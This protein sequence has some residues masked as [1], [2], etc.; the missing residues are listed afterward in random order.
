M[1]AFVG[2]ELPQPVRDELVQ[3]QAELRRAGADVNWVAAQNLHATVRF[4][5]DVTEEQRHA[6][7]QLLTGLASRTDTAELSLTHVGAFPSGAAPRVIWVGI[8]LGQG[9]LA[10]LVAELE[11]GLV[12]LGLP[13]EDRRFSAHVTLGRVRSPQNRRQLVRQLDGLHWT[14]PKPFRMIHV[15]LFQST[16]TPS[17]PIYTVLARLSLRTPVEV[18]PA[19]RRDGTQHPPA[20]R[21]SGSSTSSRTRQV[22]RKQPGE[23]L[24]A[25]AGTLDGFQEK[26]ASR[27]LTKDEHGRCQG[28]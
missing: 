16:L 9:I 6:V 24:T 20:A 26:H 11:D 21:S 1:R 19:T 13:R 3:L 22:A 28:S 25:T 8:G 5:G 10:K 18:R 4:L 2:I 12:A 14:P 17:G 15:T 7:E 23:T 27:S